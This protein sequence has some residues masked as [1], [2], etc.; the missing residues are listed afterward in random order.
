MVY[1]LIGDAAMLFHFAF[2]LYIAVGGFIAWRWPRTFWIHLGVALYG[3]AISI[4]GWTCPLTHVENWGRENAGQAGLAE[5]GF[6]DH[7]LTGVIYP[8]DDLRLVQTGVG[9]VVVLSWIVLA[10]LTRRRA[11][12]ESTTAT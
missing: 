11:R 3:L 10:V 1:R 8:A 7:Y 9:V 5:E 12:A 4:V 6:I 2:I